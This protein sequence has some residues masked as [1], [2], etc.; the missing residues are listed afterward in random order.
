MKRFFVFLMLSLGF[1]MAACG[2]E[3]TPI[4]TRTPNP[5]RTPVVTLS[6]APTL[7]STPTLLPP[8]P[9]QVALESSATPPPTATVPPTVTETRIAPTST[10]TQNP[11]TVVPAASAPTE[12]LPPGAP[13][14]PY[15]W[16]PRLDDLGIEFVPAEVDPGQW[17]W[18]LTHAEFWAEEENQGKHHIFVNVF[19]EHGARLIGETVTIAWLDGEHMLTTE[20]KPAPEYSANYPMEINHYRPWHN[21]GAFSARVN[22]LPSDRVTGMGRPPPK[23]RPV[24]FLLTFQKV[25][26]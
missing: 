9:T 25:L 14:G 17:Y 19:D 3:P 1:S 8:S 23:N 22:G 12:P 13:P 18:R 20:D 26:R 10:E 21:L 2:A 4:P 5:T 16:D 7:T 11:P 15:T 6:I 24:V